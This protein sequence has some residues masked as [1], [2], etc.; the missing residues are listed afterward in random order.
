MLSDEENN[1]AMTMF[2]YLR[3][4]LEPIVTGQYLILYVVCSKESSANAGDPEDAGLI[5]RPGRS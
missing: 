1:L 4:H 3:K 5:P 2:V